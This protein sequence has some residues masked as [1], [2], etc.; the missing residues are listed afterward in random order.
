MN[1]LDENIIASQREQL[2][3]WKI[4]FRQIGVELAR[5]GAQDRE[6]VPLLLQ[7]KQPTFFTRDFDFYR[8]SGMDKASIAFRS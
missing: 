3:R 7:L 6:L 2:Q 4:P 8:Q 5:Q 1:V